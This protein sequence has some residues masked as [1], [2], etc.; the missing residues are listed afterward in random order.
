[1]Y[2][3]SVIDKERKEEREEYNRTREDTKITSVSRELLRIFGNTK[4]L[5]VSAVACFRR[6]KPGRL[7]FSRFA[8]HF[9]SVLVHALTD[10]S[11]TARIYC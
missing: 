9:A 3:L 8:P 10:R 1:M 4:Y 5:G 11:T 6:A 7:D 2:S